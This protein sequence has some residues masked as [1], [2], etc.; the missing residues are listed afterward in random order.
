[1][2]SLLTR[3]LQHRQNNRL[4][5]R[6]LVYIIMCSTLLAVLST[7]F[8]LF[9]DYRKDVDDIEHGIQSIE[10][11]YLDSL[12][13]SLWKLDKDQIAIQ[14][15]GIMK[16]P[17]IAYASITEVVAGKEEAVFFRGSDDG[18]LPILREFELHYRDTL[19][20]RLTIGAT[21]NNVYER[22]LHK[23][24]VIL[25]AQA[26]KT[27]LVSIC[28]LIIV[29]YM[30]VRHLSTLSRYTQRLDLYNLDDD[31]KLSG[32]TFRSR[33]PDALDQLAETIN[34]MR[35]NISN[36]LKEKKKAKD[37]LEKLNEELE[38][39]V[40]YRTATLKNT[41]ERL[42]SALEELT[43][44][45]DQLVE[46]QKMAALG[47]LV[48]GVSQQLDQPLSD[49]RQQ[50][51]ELQQQIHTLKDQPTTDPDGLK[52]YLQQQDELLTRL[53]ED[54][55][56]SAELVSSFKLLAI[57]ER[58]EQS[59]RIRLRELLSQRIERQQTAIDKLGITVKLDCADDQG[60]ISYPGAWEQ[61][62]DILLDNAITHGLEGTDA[63]QLRISVESDQQQLRLSVADNGRG[64]P[65]TILPRLFDPF[66][67]GSSS[68]GSGLGTHIAYNLVTRLL[69]GTI[70]CDSERGHGSRFEIEVPLRVQTLPDD[71][72]DDGW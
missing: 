33:T 59:K 51:L 32:S 46:S 45:R 69:K 14:L 10:A 35:A 66:V 49:A 30:I 60:L 2:Q 8:Q 6:L 23:F 29:H 71:E 53:A 27:F 47:E 67:A 26:V 37:A 44:T 39:R 68:E 72:M 19:V 13:S 17:D 62:V 31:L 38:Q 7:A 65:E 20:G 61:L 36:Q 11:G 18:E 43:Q 4:S 50:L 41:N 15:D 24:F 5:Y 52:R 57:D 40:K 22:L 9:W 58:N 63:P 21:L 1:M 16:L 64:I 42:S 56:I 54:L 12:A 25:G 28:I 55:H 3:L 34:Q 70:R 48:S